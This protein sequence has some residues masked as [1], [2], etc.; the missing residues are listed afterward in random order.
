MIFSRLFCSFSGK[1]KK[2]SETMNNNYRSISQRSQRYRTQT[3]FSLAFIY[4]LIKLESP[5]SHHKFS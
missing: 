2:I 1:L 3:T 5:K 4:G